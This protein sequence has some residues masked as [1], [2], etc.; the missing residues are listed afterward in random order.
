MYYIAPPMFMLDVLFFD[1]VSISAPSVTAEIETLVM[2]ELSTLVALFFLIY[3]Y[4]RKH[5]RD[6]EG[7]ALES[8]AR[9]GH[10]RRFPRVGTA[11]EFFFFFF[12]SLT[13]L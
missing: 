6:W 4:S 10:Q 8:D 13:W 2:L 7:A 5:R 11:S 1:S 9:C 12:F 3:Q